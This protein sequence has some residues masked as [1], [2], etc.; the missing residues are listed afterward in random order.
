MLHPTN[1]PIKIIMT[2]KESGSGLISSHGWKKCWP[3]ALARTV[4]P[5]RV[6]PPPASPPSARPG[7]PLQPPRPLRLLPPL[8]CE[9]DCPCRAHL[10]PPALPP[11]TKVRTYPSLPTLSGSV[12]DPDT[13]GSEIICRIRI[14]IR[15]Y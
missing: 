15:N 9:P 7:H 2:F 4:L 6:S 3:K 11:L 5:G 10:H 14:R 13:V 1:I 8:G 12:V